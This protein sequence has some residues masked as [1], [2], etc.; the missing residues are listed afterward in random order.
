MRLKVSRKEEIFIAKKNNKL[1]KL[2][3]RDVRN[4]IRCDKRIEDELAIFRKMIKTLF[5]LV[6][7]LH[8]EEIT[9][10]VISEFL[11]HFDKVEQIK[12]TIKEE[13]GL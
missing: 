9:N 2:Y 8:T 13:L 4:A 7:S 3:E 10:E 1:Q 11:E 6:V 12:E 5:E